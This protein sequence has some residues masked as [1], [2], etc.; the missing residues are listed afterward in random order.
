MDRTRK[1]DFDDYAQQ[2]DALLARDTG[3]FADTDYFAEYKVALAAHLIAGPVRRIHEFGCGTGRNLPIIARYFPG[4]E[5]WAS[6]ISSHS[7]ELARAA[8]P[9][10]TVWQEG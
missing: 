5:I 4:A 3:F 7:L 2:Y 9:G 10:A 1:V 6:D 8:A